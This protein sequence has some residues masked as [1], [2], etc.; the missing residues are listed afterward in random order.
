VELLSLRR[1]LEIFYQTEVNGLLFKC[2]EATTPVAACEGRFSFFLPGFSIRPGERSTP[3]RLPETTVAACTFLYR[4]QGQL[5]TPNLRG[6]TEVTWHRV[7]EIC[8]P[9][10]L[11]GTV[12]I[13]YDF[14]SPAISSTASELIGTAN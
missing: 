11:F 2:R 6:I 5:Q 14:F 1:S 13:F 3:V 9:P 12:L 7:Q 8:T 10:M 4:I